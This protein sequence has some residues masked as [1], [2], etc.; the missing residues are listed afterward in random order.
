M[1]SQQDHETSPLWAVTSGS[2]SFDAPTFRCNDVTIHMRS[3]LAVYMQ[4]CLASSKMLHMKTP[5]NPQLHSSVPV[6]HE[7][8]ASPRSG[9]VLP[10]WICKVLDLV[11]LLSI[12]M[13]F[14]QPKLYNEY[15]STAT[16]EQNGLLMM[17][18]FQ[19]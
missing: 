5:P 16:P 14:C 4:T 6:A 17:W 3:F 1:L 12:V 19:C 2:A 10:T 13:K 8:T 18:L 9:L 7:G 15:Q 11:S